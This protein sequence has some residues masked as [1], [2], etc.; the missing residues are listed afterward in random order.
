MDRSRD[1]DMAEAPLFSA[2]SRQKHRVSFHMPG[3]R[4]GN[5]KA[6]VLYDQFFSFD[7]T[8]LPRTGDLADPFGHVLHAYQLA[9]EFF[10][11][12]ESWF[13]TTGTSSSIHIMLAATLH[14]G[15]AIIIPRAVHVAA[16]HALAIIGAE[17][18]FVL[19]KEGESFPDGQPDT[20]AYLRAMTQYPSAKACFVTCPDYFGRTIDLRAIVKEAKK[21]NMRVLVDEAHGAHFAAAPDLLPETALAQG[22][23]MACQSAHKTLPALTPASL[24]HLSR[25]SIE[26]GSVDPSR[27]A[28]MVKVFQTSSPSFLIAATIDRARQYLAQ[29]GHGAIRRLIEKNE[30]ISSKLPSTYRRV[31]EKG[32]DASRLVIDFS[33]TGHDRRSFIRHL[34]ETGID[35]E[36][37]DVSRAVF[38]PGLA[39]SDDDYARLLETLCSLPPVHDEA[40][41]ERHLLI[42]ETL[43][44]ARDRLLSAP[45]QFVQSPRE[46]MFSGNI[47]ELIATSPVAPYPPGLPILW[48][49]EKMTAQHQNYLKQLASQEVVIRGGELDFV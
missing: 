7:T 36:L 21:H 28:R 33:R 30:T 49:G 15:D 31:L 38:I 14:G 34:D 24:L 5:F 22:V 35:P 9:A 2:L 25:A 39:Q 46:A 18:K 3:H 32:D 13:I 48:P 16:V 41:L 29:D 40:S 27:V 8:E 4:Q 23:D 6:D 45:P 1:H 10:G 47:N 19:P 37:V 26:T 11:A 12:G 43:S 44:K 17:A 42:V 20:D